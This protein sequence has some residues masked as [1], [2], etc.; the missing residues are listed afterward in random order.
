MKNSCQHIFFKYFFKNIIS[1]YL[2][3]IANVLKGYT[4]VS[5]AL[6]IFKCRRAYGPRALK[7][8]IYCT[9]FLP[10]ISCY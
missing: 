1:E 2:A 3:D 4:L 10:L 5:W 7:T 9:P 8:F 6:K